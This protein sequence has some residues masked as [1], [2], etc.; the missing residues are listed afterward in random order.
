[1]EI[2]QAASV[3]EAILFVAGDPVDKGE[4]ARALDLSAQDTEAAL[5]ALRSRLDYDRRGLHL[6][7]FGDKAQLTIRAEY[8]P[9]VEKLLQPVQR[10]TLGQSTLETLSI[11]AYRQP[12]TRLDI[13]SIRGVKCDYSLQL[14]TAR[15]LIH[16][17]GRRDTVGHPIL[18]GTTDSFLQHFGLESLEQLPPLQPEAPEGD[19]SVEEMPI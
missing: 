17:V 7:R 19:D 14:L 18:Y 5:D 8:A 2:E 13:E 1:M 6:V 15:G 4:L 3:I 11:I 10:Q 9:Y 12:V 16:E